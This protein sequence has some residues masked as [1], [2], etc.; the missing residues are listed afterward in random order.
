VSPPSRCA[1]AGRAVIYVTNYAG[2]RALAARGITTDSAAGS[3]KSVDLARAMEA[4]GLTVTLL[5]LGWKGAT[6]SGR[7]Y[8][9]MSERID[10][11]LICE[12]AALLDFPGLNLISNFLS[13]SRLIARK[14]A[15][16]RV[17]GRACRLLIYNLGLQMTLVALYG[18]LLL[19]LPLYLQLEDGTHLI[20]TVGIARRAL[21]RLA[22]RL[23]RPLVAGVILVSNV[24]KRGYETVPHVIARGI[25]SPDLCFRARSRLDDPAVESGARPVTFLFGSGLDE[26]RG[27]R[28]LLDALEL[29]DA[30]PSFPVDRARFVITGKGSLARRVAEECQRL[31]WVR[32]DYMGFVD[33]DTYL[34]LLRNAQVGMALQDPRNPYSQACFPSKVIEYM[35]A[36]MLVLT[37]A[38]ADIEDFAKGRVVLV[39]PSSP[40][41]LVTLWRDVIEQPGRYARVAEAGQTLA[42]ERCSPLST[43][44]DIARL[45]EREHR[46]SEGRS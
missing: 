39:E 4:A 46:G 17:A 25:A 21:Y 2:P 33:V 26:I 20:P 29:A 22:H 34:T 15:Q 43:G 19:R 45:L 12:Y 27:V 16:H 36:G 24:L 42:R 41:V 18:R 10:G 5:S 1:S 11:E 37:T 35:T 23:L 7:T 38:V 44:L 8:P 28:L 13:M 30:D 6:L 32:V 3:K 9:A 14:A 31:R 40:D